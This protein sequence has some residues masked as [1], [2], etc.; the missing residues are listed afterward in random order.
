MEGHKGFI[1]VVGS[2]KAESPD[3]KERL[4]KRTIEDELKSHDIPGCYVLAPVEN[5]SSSEIW[6][7]IYMQSQEW[8]DENTLGKIYSLASGD[9]GDECRTLFQGL[10]EG[11]TPG[12]GKSARYGCWVCTL[13]E[14][15]K[16]LNNLG[17][18]YEYLKEK[19]AFRNWLVDFRD[20]NWL[21]RDEYNHRYQNEL[22][23][24][25][26]NERYGM[27]MPGGG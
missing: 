16:T 27:T 1:A 17:K 3:R 10:E 8:I 9:D 20:D 7:Y 21:Q 18:E 23:Y 14:K 11:S 13:F 19:E 24:N 15:D 4:E 25:L 12:C 2:R 26:D 6:D 5:W 22:K